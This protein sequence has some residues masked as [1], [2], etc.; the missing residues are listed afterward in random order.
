MTDWE[1]FRQA[2]PETAPK[3][4]I[5]WAM[6]TQKDELGGEL[7]LFSR[8]SVSW[9]EEEPQKIMTPEDIERREKTRRRTWGARCTCTFC[10]E[11]FAAGWLRGLKL[12]GNREIRGIALL[13]G[14]DG[15]LYEGIPDMEDACWRMSVAEIAETDHFDCPLC[16][17]DVQ[18][19]RR[20]DLRSGRTHQVQVVTVEVIH[21]V[22]VLLYWMVRRKFNEYGGS[23][24]AAW[25][26]EAIALTEKGGLKR[27]H[28]RNATSSAP[29]GTRA[30]GA[31]CGRC[32]TR[33]RSNTTAGKQTPTRKS[34][35]PSGRRCRISRGAR[36]RRPDSRTTSAQEANGRCSI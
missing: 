3:E 19:V 7:C 11:D 25:P 31:R 36:G 28:G 21:G 30:S 10:G 35:P 9:L 20:K 6:Q 26:R 14:D 8:E 12:P 2:L 18:L 34:A 29:S 4:L 5:D 1:A 22:T 13:Q 17:A 23:G 24:A 32:A 27:L 33:R 16:G 15:L